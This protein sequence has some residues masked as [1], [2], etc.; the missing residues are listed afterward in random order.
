MRIAG[1]LVTSRDRILVGSSRFLRHLSPCESNVLRN[2]RGAKRESIFP[3][4]YFITQP[5]HRMSTSL[6]NPNQPYQQQ[7]ETSLARPRWQWTH[8][9]PAMFL[10]TLSLCTITT[11]ALHLPALTGVAI[12]ALLLAC[13]SLY[14][15]SRLDILLVHGEERYCLVEL[16]GAATMLR[17]PLLTRTLNRLPIAS[18]VHVDM[19]GLSRVDHRCIESM[20]AWA[21]RHRRS[22]GSL[23][24]EWGPLHVDFKM[25]AIKGGRAQT[26]AP[27]IDSITAYRNA[28]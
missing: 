1:R 5:E 19:T 7:Y 17:L 3:I 16:R 13:G 2:F 28:A 24:I 23:A 20:M 15:R 25:E 26:D 9:S 11:F 27:P 4:N 21:A 8:M 10:A 12:G 14:E 18:D 6:D 22:G